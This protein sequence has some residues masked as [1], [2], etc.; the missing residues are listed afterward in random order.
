MLVAKRFY[1]AEDIAEW[2]LNKN[3]IQ[4][5]FED[6]EYI[7]NLKVEIKKIM[8]MLGCKTI[9]DLHKLP[10]ILSSELLVFKKQMTELLKNKGWD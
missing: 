8:L 5:N 2:F 10:V 7:T 6:S 3:R 9:D 1:R 4:M